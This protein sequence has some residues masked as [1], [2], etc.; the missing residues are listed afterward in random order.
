MKVDHG[1]AY[2]WAGAASVAVAGLAAYRL[3]PRYALASGTVTAGVIVLML[4]KH[5]G[6]FGVIG[7]P[8]LTFFRALRARLRRGA[9]DG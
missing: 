3:I 7:A 9:A 1:S 2:V 6:L 5:V 4:L 8:V